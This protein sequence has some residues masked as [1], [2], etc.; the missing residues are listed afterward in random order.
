MDTFLLVEL[1]GS[2]RRLFSKVKK[3]IIWSVLK[4]VTGMQG[5]KFKDKLPAPPGPIDEDVDYDSDDST[6]SQGAS[7]QF[8]RPRR[9]SDRAGEGFVSSIRGL[10]NLQ[11]RKA[12][13]L[14]LRTRRGPEELDLEQRS[15]SSEEEG[16]PRNPTRSPRA[17][18]GIT[19]A[20]RL[21]RLQAR[22][23]HKVNRLPRGLSEDNPR[24]SAEATP[25]QSEADVTDAPSAY[26][27]FD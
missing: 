26:E 7:E 14:V 1:S 22:K 2:W 16:N 23:H 12:K 6:G 10:F 17:I 25:S 13:A 5:K 18:P 4:S 9:H 15:S 19:K 20:K 24:H 11:R 8:V 3:H 21:L 27:D